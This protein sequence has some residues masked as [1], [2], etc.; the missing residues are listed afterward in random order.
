MTMRG[1]PAWRRRATKLDWYEPGFPRW[2]L[3]P[4]TDGTDSGININVMVVVWSTMHG[5]GGG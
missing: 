4:V 2:P 5:Q 1:E 3:D